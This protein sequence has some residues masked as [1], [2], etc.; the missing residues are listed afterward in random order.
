M[1]RTLYLFSVVILLAGTAWT[2]AGAEPGGT[3]NPAGLGL[4]IL[5][6]LQR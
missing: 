5:A 2:A 1:F 6:A 3:R 4:V